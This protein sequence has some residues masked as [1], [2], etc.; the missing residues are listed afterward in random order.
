M[1]ENSIHD[2]GKKK[3]KYCFSLPVLEKISR[4]GYSTFSEAHD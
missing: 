3:K 4:K 1:L 2:W